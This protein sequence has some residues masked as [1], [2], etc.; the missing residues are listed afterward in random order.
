[1]IANECYREANA[2][3]SYT[4]PTQAPVIPLV[5]A[6]PREST[7]SPEPEIIDV[8]PVSATSQP[9]TTNKR[10]APDDGDVSLGDDAPRKK[11]IGGDG[12]PVVV[13]LSNGN[14]TS[15]VDDE[16]VQLIE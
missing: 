10:S 15:G 14:G 13:V 4:L 12:K 8:L 6:K 16:E 7:P 11:R 9:I 5:P 2:T 3:T 1:V